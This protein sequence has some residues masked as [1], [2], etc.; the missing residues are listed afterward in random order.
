MGYSPWAHKESDTTNA[1]T[2]NTFLGGPVVE[3]PQR[4]HCRE[5]GVDSWWGYMPCGATKNKKSDQAPP[6]P[7]TL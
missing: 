5:R 3:T 6:R 4:F 7:N 1:F 2:C